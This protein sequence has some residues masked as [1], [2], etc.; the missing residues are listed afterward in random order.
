[1]VLLVPPG[2]DGVSGRETY[3]T[4][5]PANVRRILMQWTKPEFHEISLAMEV[6]AY[7]NTDANPISDGFDGRARETREESDDHA[8]NLSAV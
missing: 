6:T 7:V 1:M 2:R 8:L 4:S 5:F 3:K